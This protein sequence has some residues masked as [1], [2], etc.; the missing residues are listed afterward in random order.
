MQ[1]WYDDGCFTATLFMKR[2]Q[3]DTNEIPVS[4]LAQRAGNTRPFL[5]PINPCKMAFLDATPCLTIRSQRLQT[6]RLV[7]RSVRHRLARSTVGW[8]RSCTT[9]ASFG[10]HIF[11]FQWWAI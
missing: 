8:I 10:L 3:I 4:E 11:D 7:P 1:K 5:T 2:N 9:V 6:G